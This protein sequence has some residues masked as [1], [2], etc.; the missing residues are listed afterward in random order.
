MTTSPESSLGKSAFRSVVWASLGRVVRAGSQVLFLIILGRS[1]G[2]S[3]FAAASIALIGYQLVVTVA[4]QSFAQALVRYG[5]EN[6]ARDATAFWLNLGFSAGIALI[7][8]SASTLA[9]RILYLPD[10]VWLMPLLALIATLAAPTVIAQANFSRTMN[11]KYIASIESLSAFVSV[12]VGLLSIWIGELG[13]EALVIY[14]LSQRIVE[15][16]AFMRH[17]SS[18]PV[19]RPL[20]L[21]FAP[22]MSFT[23]PL[24]TVQI[25]TFANNSVDQFFIGRANDS[26]QLGLFSLGRRLTQ[27]P[28]QMISFAVGR[29]I[30]PALVKARNTKEGPNG[31]FLAS[32]RMAALA[33]SAPLFFF[34]VLANELVGMVLGTEWTPSGPFIALFAVSSVT[35]PLGAVC[36]AALRAEGKTRVQLLLQIIRLFITITVLGGC[37]VMAADIWTMASAVALITFTSILPPTIVSTRH[38]GIPFTKAIFAIAKGIFPSAVISA[39][40]AAFNLKVMYAFEPEQR[41]LVSALWFIVAFAILILIL[42]KKI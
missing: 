27:H 2:P 24:I 11:F 33:S 40:L 22:L 39:L 5:D 29:A 3:G 41:I 6:P 10:L 34:A 12:V 31:L 17:R 38:L 15:C 9:T 21:A 36:A 42:R 8:C 14:T 30:F 37:V 16:F 13:L 19:A 28:T 7:V 32:L 35:A 4:S 18:W 20:R 25:L 26:N 23:A 1:V